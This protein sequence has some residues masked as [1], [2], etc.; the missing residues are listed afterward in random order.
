MEFVE[1]FDNKRKAL[2]KVTERYNYVEGEY[3]QGAHVWI[4]NS[5]GELLIQKRTPTKKLYPNLWSITSGGTDTGETTLETAF[6]EVK[7]EL[8]ITLKPEELE[9]MMSYKRNHDFVDVYLAKKDINLEDIVMQEEEVAEVKW[10]K[11]EE[12]EELIKENQ[13]PKSL[14][15]YFGFLRELIG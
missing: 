7:E 12:L 13:T 5:K 11:P 1:M 8:G 9:L 3:S 15:M 14:E 10:V 6:R 4:T 2:G